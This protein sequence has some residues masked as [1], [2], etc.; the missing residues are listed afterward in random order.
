MADSRQIP[1]HL[2]KLLTSSIETMERLEVLLYLREHAT[3]SF[4]ARSIAKTVG[5]ALVSAEQNLA[6][7][8]GRGF[9]TVS[10]GAD[11]LYRYQPVSV[12][13]DAA[14]GEIE[15]IYRGGRDSLASLLESGGRREEGPT[16]AN[17]FLLKKG[18]RTGGHSE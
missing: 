13:V 8:C 11:L 14:I 1:E 3:K 10:I 7:L 17:A 9:L 12:V 16:F 6:V 18:E 4:G 15:G 2:V 5:G